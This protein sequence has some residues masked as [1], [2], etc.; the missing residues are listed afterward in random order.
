MRLAGGPHESVKQSSG[1]SPVQVCIRAYGNTT[2]HTTD[3]KR[4]GAAIT[5][6]IQTGSRRLVCRGI[7]NFGRHLAQQTTL[8]HV[9]ETPCR[10]APA[11]N[12]TR[13]PAVP[14]DCDEPA[15]TPVLSCGFP[16][17][18]CILAS[19]VAVHEPIHGIHRARSCELLLRASLAR[20]M[21]ER[22]AFNTGW[23]GAALG[24]ILHDSPELES[25]V[26]SG[27]FHV[28]STPSWG[29]AQAPLSVPT[30]LKVLLSD[31]IFAA[32]NEPG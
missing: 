14:V 27:C 20:K 9:V 29:R 18:D 26:R 4:V 8:G 1:T 13:A 25:Q 31:E 6:G 16:R 12:S 5:P 19:T 24:R 10:Q 21:H 7:R 2:S 11:I 15:H 23:L 30:R 28:S 22:V 3:S 32:V 17:N